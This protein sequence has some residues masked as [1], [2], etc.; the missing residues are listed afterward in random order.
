MITISIEQIA[1][2]SFILLIITGLFA[3]FISV[4]QQKKEAY[5]ERTPRAW[6]LESDEDF[7]ARMTRH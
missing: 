4:R 1:G 6:E 3:N 7:I 2:V 5:G